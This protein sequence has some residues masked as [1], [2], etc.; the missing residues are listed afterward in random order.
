MSA[1]WHPDVV[2][3]ASL[4]AELIGEQFPSLAPI[5][6]RVLAKGWDNTAMLVNDAFVFRFPR[7]TMAVPL[8]STEIQLLPWLAPQLPVGIPV[9]TYIGQ[10]SERYQW[11]FAG[12]RYIGGKTLDRASVDVADRGTL[13]VP[14]ARFLSALHA[15]PTEHAVS[16]GAV[17]DTLG[18]LDSARRW[19][20]TKQRLEGL[21]QVLSQGE[22]TQI[23]CEL[24]NPGHAEPT[25]DVLV[26]G[27]LHAGQ[28][29]VNG[30][31]LTG[32]IDWGDV[33]IGNRA[34]DFA[35]VQA[36]LPSSVHGQF[37]RAYGSVDESIWTTARPR[38]IWHTVALL[39]RAFDTQDVQI[40][41]DASAALRRLLA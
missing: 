13:T 21:G 37:L 9:P 24:L 31:E 23:E 40:V 11:P 8:L 39:A 17:P 38:A 5:L 10:A 3:D 34:V 29:I 26:H 41:E 16:H 30:N 35:G 25:S 2:V 6:A 4:A 1:V 33:H 22:R 12:Y 18:R 15:I 7:R 14:L 20:V 32:V 27:D 28:I 19:P 36:I